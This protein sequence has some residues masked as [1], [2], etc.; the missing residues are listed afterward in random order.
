MPVCSGYKEESIRFLKIWMGI[1]NFE[2]RS[3]RVYGGNSA[4]GGL[5][6]FNWNWSG[7]H[8]NNQS[9]CP[10]EVLWKKQKSS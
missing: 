5:A 3:D 10:L 4:Y 8:W 1:S 2:D 7:N 9:F 6:N